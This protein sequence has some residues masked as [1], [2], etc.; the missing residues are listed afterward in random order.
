MKTIIFGKESNLTHS[1]KKKIKT[2]CFI[3]SSRDFYINP[4]EYIKILNQN[5]F[6]LIINASTQSNNFKNIY[7][8]KK[9]INESIDSIVIL[10]E[11]L[12]TNKIKKIIFSSS[13]SVNNLVLKEIKSKISTSLQASTKLIMENI[14]LD[15]CKKNNISHNICRIN[16]IFGGNDNFSIIHKLFSKNKSKI[17]ISNNGNPTR[18]FIHVDE[19]ANIYLKLIN[20]SK[21]DGTINIGSGKSYRIKE[22]IDKYKLNNKI[23]FLNKFNRE[24]I[25]QYNN[26]SSINH[27]YKFKSNLSL[28]NYLNKKSKMNIKLDN[29]NPIKNNKINLVC[30]G[31]GIVARQIFSF[32]HDEYCLDDLAFFVDDDPKLVGKTFL[33]KPVFSYDQLKIVS[34]S[35]HISKIV[36]AIANIS[37]KLK[38]NIFYK[39]IN[40]TENIVTVPIKSKLINNEISSSDLELTSFEYLFNK[41]TSLITIQTLK[42][43]SKKNILVTGGAGS[44]GSELVSQLIKNKNT[45]II[46]LD[47]S[48]YALYLLNKKLE[49]NKNNN[50]IT[51][52][53]DVNDY[54]LLKYLFKKYKF[55]YVYHAA[56]YKHVNLLEDNIK[57]AI[58]NNILSTYTL[59]KVCEEYTKLIKF[60]FIS[61][62]KADNPKS[63]LGYTKRFGE[64]LCQS[65]SKKKYIEAHIVRFGNVFASRGS[66]IPLFVKQIRD[67]D[68][69]TITNK[70][71]ER[72]FMSIRQACSLVIK[73]SLFQYSKNKIFILDMGKPIKILDLIYKLN[74][75][76]G[77]NNKLKIKEIGLN[78]GEKLKETLSYNKKIF[79][80]KV[81]DILYINDS[82][83]KLKETLLFIEYIKNNI[84]NNEYEIIKKIKILLNK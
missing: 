79:P 12:N 26:S 78:K 67:N 25:I 72:Y 55:N 34:E 8:Y 13:I 64:I 16:N 59:L 40:I 38:K 48:E 51:I 47:N 14:I 42:S 73:T 44:I 70:K 17:A 3:I 66:V 15:F 4:K 80:S 37:E 71:A 81:K 63:V 19:V 65:F 9:F 46:I 56:A 45:N 11:N 18:D 49:S 24:M 36:V 84:D 29:F 68:T 21:Y 77:S 33:G 52:L 20:T 61:T 23:H 2:N 32:K 30:Y 82:V 62:D 39:L 5:N 43:L 35:F 27:F 74:S 83:Y 75:I 28:N 31:T 58:Q 10:L 41:D 22:I 7:S 76:Y 60:I 57:S 69:V 1:L 53:G 6:K 54:R 50:F